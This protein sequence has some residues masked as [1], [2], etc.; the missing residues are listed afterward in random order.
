M[1]IVRKITK[2]FNIEGI[3]ANE[4]TEHL[5]FV[6]TPEEFNNYINN[7]YVSSNFAMSPPDTKTYGMGSKAVTI[8]D[9]NKIKCPIEVGA[10]FI[11][12]STQDKKLV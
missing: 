1:Y 3:E 2:H 9:L 12:V 7:K 11:I 5:G 6:S 4:T 8:V 10:I